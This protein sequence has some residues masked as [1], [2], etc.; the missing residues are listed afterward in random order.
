MEQDFGAKELQRGPRG[1]NKHG[2][3]GQ[4]PWLRGAYPFPPCCSD[5]VNLHLDGFVLT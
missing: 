3:R 5:A 4:I 1:P 2:P